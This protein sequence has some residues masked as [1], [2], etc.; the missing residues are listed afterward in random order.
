MQSFTLY[1]QYKLRRFGLFRASLFAS[2]GLHVFC[3]LIYFVLTLPSNAA[4]QETSIEDMD[5]SF[6]EIPP[7]LIG[8]TSSPAP[9]EKQE[10]VE[11]SN[12]EA[13]EK[14]DNS[15]LNPNQLSGNGT[16]KDGYLFSFN[17]DRPPTPIIDFDLKA[18]FPEAAKA[19]NI[20]QK[21]VVVMV[22]VDEHGQ[23]QGVK[24]VSGRAGYGFDEAAIRIIQRARF[25]PGY[26]KGKPTR[27][28]HRLPISFDLEED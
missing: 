12:K 15:D 6:E 9:V 20:S 14:P 4:F 2:V 16:D 7:E 22:Q 10:W 23:L 26:D 13:E 27:M 17:G 5:V 28:A 19:A 1:L 18:Y 11:G 8:G 21:T 24:I 25:S 3:Y